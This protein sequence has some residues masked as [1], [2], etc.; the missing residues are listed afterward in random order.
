MRDTTHIRRLI[1]TPRSHPQRLGIALGLVLAATFLRWIIDHG[2]RGVPFTTYYPAVLLAALL[3]DWRY[4]VLVAVAC[5]AVV[6]RVF[7]APGWF[8][9][10]DGARLALFGL[11]ALSSGLL[12]VTGATVRHL[13]GD[14]EDLMERQSG[15]NVE[16]Q[17]RIKNSLAIVQAMASQGVKAADPAEFYK[18]LSLRIAALAKANELLCVGSKQDCRMPD[19]AQQAV[20]PFNN[21]GQIRLHGQECSLPEISCIP[22]VM[23]LHELCTNA[24][25]HGALSADDGRVDLTWQSERRGHETDLVVEWQ[26]SGGPCVQAPTHRGLGSRLLVA[27][28][29][30]AGLDVEFAPDGV[31]C[32]IRV[33]GVAPDTG[34]PALS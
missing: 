16:L 25:K 27:Q 29:G 22:M 17:H 11:F 15:Y 21:A 18:S 24:V 6:N 28:K 10:F 14:I 23:V 2:A 1:L 5:A 3:L 31:R 4:A 12:V 30:I 9:T 26:E 32:L 20:A 8:V 7:M 19:L 34:T 33:M 13:L